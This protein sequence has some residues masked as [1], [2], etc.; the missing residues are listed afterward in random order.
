MPAST[1]PKNGNSKYTPEQNKDIKEIIESFRPINTQVDEL[2]KRKP[3]RDCVFNLLKTEG[4]E[5]LLDLITNILPITNTQQYSSVIT[6]P[7]ALSNKLANLKIFISKHPELFN[8]TPFEEMDDDA[9]YD[10]PENQGYRCVNS[11]LSELSPEEQEKYLAWH[12]Q[13]QENLIKA[14]TEPIK[15]IDYKSFADDFKK[16]DNSPI[17]LEQ[18]KKI[19]LIDF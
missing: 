3:E 16:K 17:T 18:M 13:Y 5:Y 6:K 11:K 4:K 12:K 2:F 19:K 9:F 7:S 1:S 15:P 8:E 14:K 10:L